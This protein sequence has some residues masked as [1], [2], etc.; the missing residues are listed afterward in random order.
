MKWKKSKHGQFIP[1][2]PEKYVGRYPILPRSS[3]EY[4]FMQWLDMNSSI[5]EWSSESV[6]IQ[7]YDP[8]YKKRRRYYPD[9]Y[10]L[11]NKGNK[12]QQFIVEIKPHKEI[13]PPRRGRKSTS[14]RI[15]EQKTYETNTAKWNAAEVWCRK[16]GMRFM[17]LTEKELFNK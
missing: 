17:I 11:V 3:W 16:M 8:V 15:Y 5:I 12:E 6:T 2:F 7:Y 14:T 1:K 4:S 9:F 13:V 10:M